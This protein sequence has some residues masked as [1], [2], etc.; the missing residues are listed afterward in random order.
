MRFESKL[1]EKLSKSRYISKTSPATI[2]KIIE[3]L[4][5]KDYQ[6]ETLKIKTPCKLDRL[7]LLLSGS[8]TFSEEKI[9]NNEEMLGECSMF[10]EPEPLLSTE[11]TEIILTGYIAS[12][13]FSVLGNILSSSHALYER[14]SIL[15][16][17]KEMAKMKLE[18]LIFIKN[19][20]DGLFGPIYLVKNDES[21]KLFVLK[22][23]SKAIVCEKNLEKHIIVIFILLVYF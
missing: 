16:E 5:L 19:F 23:I 7:W 9:L 14:K 3:S 17:R 13:S 21:N 15:K 4:Y 10:D 18:D 22:C 12:I 6:T 8:M 2:Q 11:D 20:G 1:K